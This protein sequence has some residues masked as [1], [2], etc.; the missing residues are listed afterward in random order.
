MCY[1]FVVYEVDDVIN[2]GL[3]DIFGFKNGYGGCL[4]CI[5]N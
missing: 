3:K 4:G 5:F 2:W 1:F